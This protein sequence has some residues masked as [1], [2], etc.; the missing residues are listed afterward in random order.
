MAQ[1]SLS[2]FP[3]SVTDFGNMSNLTPLF[4]SDVIHKTKI[5]V[6]A[7][8]TKAAASTGVIMEHND[9]VMKRKVICDRPFAYAII[10]LET[11]LPIF[12]GTVEHVY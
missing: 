12:F 11:R 9:V 6:N 5:E 8:G 10:D 3:V 1:I 2:F 4:I 7:E